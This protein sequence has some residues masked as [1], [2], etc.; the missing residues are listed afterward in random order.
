[1]K[2]NENEN[3]KDLKKPLILAGMA[4]LLTLIG[5]TGA[6]TYAKYVTSQEVPSQQATVAKW[7]YV[8]TVN[9]GNLF[10]TN[11]AKDDET[12]DGETTNAVVNKDGTIIVSSTADTNVIAPGATGSMSIT[13]NGSA[14]ILSKL[15]FI[16]DKVKVND[17]SVDYVKDGQ[18]MTYS[19]I[20]WSLAKGEKGETKLVT[21]ATLKNALDEL[22]KQ[23]TYIDAG[24]SMSDTYILSYSWPFSTSDENDKH[25]TALGLL[26]AGE[27]VD[28]Y[29]EV[30]NE[31]QLALKVQLEQVQTK[32]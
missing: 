19:P 12:T 7:G 16:Y 17:I 3:K 14:E 13:I 31:V 18:T 22:V 24:T 26:A 10:G 23:S 20:Q 1:M 28:G 9:T 30:S 2:H 32:K 25:D 21:D 4:L 5:V 8:V 11:Y 6:S 27:T 29:T 15:S